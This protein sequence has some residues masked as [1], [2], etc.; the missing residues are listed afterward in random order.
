MWNTYTKVLAATDFSQLGNEAVRVAYGQA[1]PTK[2]EVIACHVLTED[3]RKWIMNEVKCSAGDVYECARM[4]LNRMVPP[5]ARRDGVTLSTQVVEGKPAEMLLDLAER[6]EVDLIVT[7][8]HGRTG[9][10]RLILGS[11]AEH[12]VRMAHASVL[13]VKP[14]ESKKTGSTKG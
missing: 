14:Q 7:G 4:L 13:V 8:T 6:N 3:S 1:W 11:V 2:S 10:D 9:L 5:N 12:L